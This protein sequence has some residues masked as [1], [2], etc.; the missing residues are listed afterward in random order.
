MSCLF[1]SCATRARRNSYSDSESASSN[2]KLAELI[3]N[4]K[5]KILLLGPG[6]AGK[7]TILNQIRRINDQYD[8]KL[9]DDRRKVRYALY[10]KRSRYALYSK[11]VRLNLSV[12]VNSCVIALNARMNSV[13]L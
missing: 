5:M 7:T 11:A 6:N 4:K 9:L 1:V 13:L 10:S 3:E 12:F 2:K 8:K